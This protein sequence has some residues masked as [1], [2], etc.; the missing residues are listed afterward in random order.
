M[1]QKAEFFVTT[2]TRISEPTYR[3]HAL[4]LK[5]GVK[6]NVLRTQTEAA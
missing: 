5:G 6:G 1:S 2:A 3:L 4:K